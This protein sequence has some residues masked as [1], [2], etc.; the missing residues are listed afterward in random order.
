MITDSIIYTTATLHSH[1]RLDPSLLK[2]LQRRFIS[3]QTLKTPLSHLSHSIPCDIPCQYQ[4]QNSIASINHNSSD[5]LTVTTAYPPEKFSDGNKTMMSPHN[6]DINT[7]ANGALFMEKTDI[8]TINAIDTSTERE[9]EQHHNI[10]TNFSPSSHPSGHQRRAPINSAEDADLEGF[11]LHSQPTYE[12]VLSQ[13]L[14]F[15]D[16][17]DDNKNNDVSKSGVRTHGMYRRTSS[18]LCGGDENDDNHGTSYDN[19]GTLYDNHGTLYVSTSTRQDS[20]AHDNLNSNRDRIDATSTKYIRNGAVNVL[21]DELDAAI[22]A[23]CFH[24][25]KGRDS[26]DDAL[27]VDADNAHGTCS[28]NDDDDNDGEVGSQPMPTTAGQRHAFGDE[29]HKLTPAVHSVDR[30]QLNRDNNNAACSFFPIFRS[31]KDCKVVYIVRHGE[32]EFNAAVTAAGSQW[33]EPLLFDAP[34]TSR[35]KYQAKSLRKHVSSWN[36]PKDVVWVTSP[37]TRAIE[38]MLWAH[39]GINVRDDDGNKMMHAVQANAMLEDCFE[40]VFVLPMIAERLVTSGDIGRKP[41]DLCR[42]F[43]ALVRQLGELPE[44]WWYSRPGK[45]NCPYRQM[46]QSSETKNEMQKRISMF[47][48]WLL[49]RPE[50]V[51]VAVGHSVFWKAFATSCHNGIRQESLKNCGWQVLHV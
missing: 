17:G 24:G 37:L 21:H 32:S 10:G 26:M 8:H 51:F 9:I 28:N 27:S 18:D 33:A 40:R 31:K 41:A 50:K 23:E 19:H 20:R 5:E 34:L 42:R 12:R 14:T 6:N 39:P 15:E 43:P 47:R 22:S 35:G 16:V 4:R 3:Q 46:F 36:L 44:E 29:G 30:V 2:S 48:K 45:P 1:R 49:A 38:T 7:N 13:R 11:V 25:G